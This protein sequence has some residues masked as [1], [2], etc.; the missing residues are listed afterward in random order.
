M[1]LSIDQEKCIGCGLCVNYCPTDVIRLDEEIKKAFIA[2]IEDCMTCYNCELE[3]PQGA[4][5]VHPFKKKQP[6][7]W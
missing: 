7:A 1:I 4:I 6:Q 5:E 2:Y 3:C